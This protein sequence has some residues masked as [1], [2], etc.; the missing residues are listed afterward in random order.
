MTSGDLDP[1][2]RQP[3]RPTLQEFCNLYSD[4]ASLRRKIHYDNTEQFI[5]GTPWVIEQDRIVID[6]P[7]GEPR[8]RGVL[9]RGREYFVA[10]NS[11][12]PNIEVS[13]IK[14]MR[15]YAAAIA[16]KAWTKACDNTNIK[17]QREASPHYL[18]RHIDSPSILSVMGIKRKSALRQQAEEK[19][20]DVL[21]LN[22]E[23]IDKLEGNDLLALYLPR[24]NE[25]GLLVTARHSYRLLS[26]YKCAAPSTKQRVIRQLRARLDATLETDDYVL[27]P[28]SNKLLKSVD[29]FRAVRDFVVEGIDDIANPIDKELIDM[30]SREFR[31]T[32]ATF[33]TTEALSIEMLKQIGVDINEIYPEKT[34]ENW[35][36]HGVT[37]SLGREA[38]ALMRQR[39]AEERQHK[40]EEI[41]EKVNNIK[42]EISEISG[43]AAAH[44]LPWQITKHE[45]KKRGLS[46]ALA[47]LV[48]GYKNAAGEVI[49]AG[50]Q[51]HE[52]HSLI[53]FIEG[54]RLILENNN[55]PG[56][57]KSFAENATKK[58]AEIE[59]QLSAIEAKL[60]A[61]PADIQASLRSMLPT[62]IKT[63]GGIEKIRSNWSSYGPLVQNFWPN[64]RSVVNQIEA[65][66]INQTDE[67][68]EATPSRQPHTVELHEIP[69][70]ESVGPAGLLT[71]IA[72][73]LDKVILPPQASIQD[74]ET[75]VRQLDIS[76]EEA[77]LIDWQR[78]HNL[79]KVRDMYDGALYRSKK[80]SLGR[81]PPYFVV[82]IVY[83]DEAYA[84]AES[85][86]EGNATYIVAEKL[87]PGNWL[88]I[89][90][91]TKQEARGFGAIRIV[92][93]SGQSN[94]THIQKIEDTLIDLMVAKPTSS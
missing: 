8:D 7:S 76:E 55:T 40:K 72:E 70:I 51:K 1:S 16:P 68:S 31:N 33:Q 2:N 80:G 93:R 23:E 36:P 17:A 60:G 91:L 84:I 59:N 21:G 45:L 90:S 57:F 41:T 19:V 54:I 75:A 58:E 11:K 35:K 29:A 87:S 94:R 6:R 9:N 27:I 28:S 82:E 81:A 15:A 39:N 32:V 86:V 12:I 4:V 89:L 48:R 78:L 25:I 63:T 49:M 5:R 62:L 83:E 65:L 64:G 18:E 30:E 77:R 56:S 42:G 24:I 13:I 79:V 37:A 47:V 26:M 44:N 52:A 43:V 67:S 74:V 88:E 53:G 66:I 85:P 3:G 38:V 10:R 50:I 71:S 69:L 14:D 34:R 46:D 92:H 61:L 22:S 73:Q 20:R